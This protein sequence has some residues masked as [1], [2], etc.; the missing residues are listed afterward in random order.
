MKTDSFPK[1]L[2]SDEYKNLVVREL[3]GEVF[4]T[5]HGSE[6]DDDMKPKVRKMVWGGHFVS[7]LYNFKI[8][9]SSCYSPCFNLISYSFRIVFVFFCFFSF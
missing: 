1:F 2:R 6:A 7:T 4:E 3:A 9:R 5:T 8:A